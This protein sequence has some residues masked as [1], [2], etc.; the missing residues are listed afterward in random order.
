MKRGPGKD[1]DVKLLLAIAKQHAEAE[2]KIKKRCKRG[3]LFA[4]GQNYKPSS[5]RQI[6][7]L[8]KTCGRLA[9]PTDKTYWK[10]RARLKEAMKRRPRSL[11]H[12]LIFQWK[13]WQKLLAGTATIAI[14]L[15]AF[16]FSFSHAPYISAGGI[17]VNIIYGGVAVNSSEGLRKG[18]DGQSVGEGDTLITGDWENA[19]VELQI[20]NHA[21]IRL[22]DNTSVKIED[23]SQNDEVTLSLEGKIWVKT[24]DEESH[25][26]LRASESTTVT[27]PRGAASILSNARLTKV[28]TKENIALVEVMNTENGT[29]KS[30]KVQV[31]EEHV[32]NIPK[33]IEKNPE[34]SIE[35]KKVANVDTVLGGDGEGWIEENEK[36]DKVFKENLEQQKKEEMKKVA[37]TL[38]GSPLYTAKKMGEEAKLRALPENEKP[39]AR[40]D[41]AKIRLHE[42]IVL[43]DE[44][45]S[46]DADAVLEEYK[47]AIQ[48]ITEEKRY[49]VQESEILD[50]LRKQLEEASKE[51]SLTTAPDSDTYR[52]KEAVEEL[53]IDTS[54]E[55]VEE[56]GSIAKEK[57]YEILQ[58]LEEGKEDI[59][60]IHF[61][62]YADMTQESLDLAR[63][64]MRQGD[65]S[66]AQKIS[67]EKNEIEIPLLDLIIEESELLREK[68]EELKKMT[69]TGI[70]DIQE[71]VSEEPTAV[72]TGVAYKDP[73]AGKEEEDSMIIDEPEEKSPAFRVSGVAR[74]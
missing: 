41:Q 23:V 20:F 49:G 15:G 74:K 53:L 57:L 17:S 67:I 10:V 6:E 4:V 12:H 68:A 43:F 69:I 33:A 37:G 34:V 62:E 55:K 9:S 22:G 47:D 32:I 63:L 54:D 66:A 24:F 13:L 52:A 45:K 70:K 27:V 19:L 51:L 3:V 28:M 30:Q 31:P 42:A 61:S 1:I 48:N 58:L 26:K 71:T 5:L 73:D 25:L 39:L 29:V 56:K 60:L 65:D 16:Q 64:L 11:L 46:E 14:L 8:L 44:G 50:A 36:Q 59:A 7:R 35:S 18:Y 72:L 2:R 40:L 21:I 38:P